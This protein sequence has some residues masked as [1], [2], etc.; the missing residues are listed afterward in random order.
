MSNE[1]ARLVAHFPMPWINPPS[2]TFF[3]K[4][5]VTCAPMHIQRNTVLTL[6]QVLPL[7]LLQTHHGTTLHHIHPLT[8]DAT[9]L[10]TTSCILFYF[11]SP[12][13]LLKLSRSCYHTHRHCMGTTTMVYTRGMTI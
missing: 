6:L 11:I 4:V 3:V 5:L 12:F 13:L 8:S 10:I 1:V 7:P 9:T 2:N